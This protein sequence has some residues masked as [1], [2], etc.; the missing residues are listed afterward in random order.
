MK[1]NYILLCSLFVSIVII[2]SCDKKEE[3]IVRPIK[4][5]TSIAGKEMAAPVVTAFGTTAKIYTF[6]LVPPL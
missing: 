5:R 2:L 4:I 3:Q 1:K 6:I